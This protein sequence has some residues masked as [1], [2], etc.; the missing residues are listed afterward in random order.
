MDLRGRLRRKP[1]LVTTLLL[2]SF[3]VTP[4]LCLQSSSQNISSYGVVS[5]SSNMGWLRTDGKWIVD[6][7]GNVVILRGANFMGYE[8]GAWKSH[9]EEDYAK[10]ASW[11]FNVVRLPIAWDYIEPQ[12]GFYNS[13]YFEKHVDRDIAWAKKCGIYIIL[14][15]HQYHL[16]R[17]FTYFSSGGSRGNGFPEWAVG[18]YSD[19]EQ[20]EKDAFAAFWDGLGPNGTIPSESNPSLQDRYIN[21]WKYVASRYAS[22]Q[23]IVGYDLFN[24]PMRGNYSQWRLFNSQTLPVF[25]ERVIDATRSK[26]SNHIIMW[27]PEGGYASSNTIPPD[28]ADLVYS[29]HKY[30]HHYENGSYDGDISKMESYMQRIISQGNTWSQPIF[31][32]EYGY[33]LRDPNAEQWFSD[34][35]SIFNKYIVSG[36][37]EVYWKSDTLSY[38][39][40][41]ANGTEK[42]HVNYVDSPYPR[43]SSIQPYSFSFDQNSKYFVVEMPKTNAYESLQVYIPTRHYMNDFMINST[44]NEWSKVWSPSDRILRITILCRIEPSIKLIVTIST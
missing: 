40:L 35:I 9:T 43:L 32:G 27:E 22:E 34:T 15:M 24:E 23:A 28:R 18:N 29:P 25:Y 14:D 4:I 5:Y 41:Y 38:D 30:I 36:A 42:V 13:S 16:S 6:G 10:M 12:P 1:Y 8:F 19:S 31:I 11:G 37:V 7:E 20:G 39:L 3:L 44:A 21:V 2:I 33:I 26:D 17:H